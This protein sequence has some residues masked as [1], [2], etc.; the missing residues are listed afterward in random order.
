MEEIRITLIY[1]GVRINIGDKKSYHYLVPGISP[2]K[3][4]VYCFNKKLLGYEMVGTTLEATKTETR[5]KQP[6]D[7]KGYLKL[8]DVYYEEVLGWSIDDR[9]A[10]SQA[11]AI[12]EM[13]KGPDN[14]IEVLVEKIRVN[15]RHLGCKQRMRIARYIFEKIV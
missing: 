15:T 6:Y 7:L 14:T 9:S 3:D 11:Q 13:K 10:K 1:K 2:I 8:G 12:S 5:V 4:E